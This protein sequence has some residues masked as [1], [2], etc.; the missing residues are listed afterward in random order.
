MDESADVLL[1]QDGNISEN[2]ITR[3]H[4]EWTQ[5]PHMVCNSFATSYKPGLKVQF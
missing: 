3:D 4:L 1:L 2:L 5:D